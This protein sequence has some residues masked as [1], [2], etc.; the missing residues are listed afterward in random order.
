MN[1][2]IIGYALTLISC[3]GVAF[4]SMYGIMDGWFN[5]DPLVMTIFIIVAMLNCCGAWEMA[6]TIINEQ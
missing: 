6:M 3:L 5:H 4:T 2:S 1:K